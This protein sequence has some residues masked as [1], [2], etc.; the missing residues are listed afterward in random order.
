MSIAERH[1]LPRQ[2]KQHGLR[3]S[4][5]RIADSPA[6]LRSLAIGYTREAGVRRLDQ[7]IAALC[8]HAA[9]RLA[10]WR[11]EQSSSQQRRE[12]NGV[13]AISGGETRDAAGVE[14]EAESQQG[15]GGTAGVRDR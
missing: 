10:R 6:L 7:K 1:L 15:G 3:P 12:V 13:D 9:L 4:H 8:R 5:L 11:A 14:A 2:L